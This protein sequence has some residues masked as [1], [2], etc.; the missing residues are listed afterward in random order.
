MKRTLVIIPTYNERETLPGVIKSILKYEEF[1][2]LVVDD[3]SPDGSGRIVTEIMAEEKTVHL[4]ERPGKFGLGTAYVEGFKWGLERGYDYL[5]EMDADNSHDPDSLH[6]FMEEMGKG[7]D[8]VIGSRYIKSTISV[9]GWDFR[10]LMISKFGNFYASRILGLHLTD[11]TSGYRSYSRQA[12]GTIDLDK[13]HSN[14]YAF[15][16]EMAYRVAAAGRKVGEIPIIFRERESGESKM[17]GQIIREAAILPWK[18]R[19]SRLLSPEQQGMTRDVPYQM[20]TVAGVLFIIA[21]IIGS[22]V[23]GWWLGTEGDII[24]IIHKAKMSLP[25]WAWLVMKI[26]L[27]AISALF[28]VALFLATAVVFFSIGDRK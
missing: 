16:I 3:A 19:L 8:L 9:V 6:V 20:R 21:G 27:S 4:I 12:L 2:V 7:F 17:S 18:L 28:L 10:R 22:M 14:G 15:Q 11:L 5:V 13:L 26:S 23:S 1:D 24:E 25:G